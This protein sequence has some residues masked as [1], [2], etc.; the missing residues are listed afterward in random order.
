MIDGLLLRKFL[1]VHARQ[2]GYRSAAT[3][4]AALVDQTEHEHARFS[5][6]ELV[7]AVHGSYTGWMGGRRAVGVLGRLGR[8][9]PHAAARTL[10]LVTPRLFRWLVGPIRRTGPTELVVQRCRF[11]AETSPEICLRVCKGPTES[12]FTD[13]L[14]VPTTLTPD[15]RRSTCRVSFAPAPRRAR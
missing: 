5:G 15:L 4:Y 12:F 14:N 10:T 8:R 9:T 13:T 6:A 7:S 11:L 1:R 3:G 2:I